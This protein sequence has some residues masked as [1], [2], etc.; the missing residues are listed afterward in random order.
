MI[1]MC[2]LVSVP[3]SLGYW[4]FVVSFENRICAYSDFVLLCQNWFGG[5]GSLVFP[6]EFYTLS[7]SAK[8]T[9]N[10]P[11]KQNSQLDSEGDYVDSVGRFEE[12]CH[13]NSIKSSSP[14]YAISFQFSGLFKISFNDVPFQYTSLILLLLHLFVSIFLFDAIANGVVCLI[15]F[16]IVHC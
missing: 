2:V 3:N 6:R 10:K 11:K 7:I 4:S 14:W 15:S 8:K 13:L 16:H 9:Q 1:Y 5:S 12:Y